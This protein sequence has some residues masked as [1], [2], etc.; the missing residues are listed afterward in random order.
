MNDENIRNPVREI[1]K[2][3]EELALTARCVHLEWK[4]THSVGSISMRCPMILTDYHSCS[5]RIEAMTLTDDASTFYCIGDTW[6]VYSDDPQ[7]FIVHIYDLG[8]QN[9]GVWV[10]IE[11]PCLT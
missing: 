4:D 1:M 11:Q 8:A 6:K 10:S 9:E 7:S 2:R 5:C 3:M